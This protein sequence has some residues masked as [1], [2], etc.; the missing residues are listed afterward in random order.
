MTIE[1]MH[2]NE[3]QKQNI[4]RLGRSVKVT[5]LVCL[6]TSASRVGGLIS[7]APPLLPKP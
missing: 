2:G 3:R 7:S 6:R 4:N 1:G 5:A